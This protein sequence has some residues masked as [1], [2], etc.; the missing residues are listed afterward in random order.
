M[1]M[2]SEG[3]LDFI[4]IQNDASLQRTHHKKHRRI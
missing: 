1:V 3:Q 4:Q 2:Q